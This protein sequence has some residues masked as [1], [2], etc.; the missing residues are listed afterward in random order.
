MPTSLDISEIEFIEPEHDLI[1]VPEELFFKD[2]EA[3]VLRPNVIPLPSGVAV[4]MRAVF[5]SEKVHCAR[6]KD[7]LYL[8]ADTTNFGYCLFKFVSSAEND[9]TFKVAFQG[10]NRIITK[11][12]SNIIM[13]GNLEAIAQQYGQRG[14]V[15][16]MNLGSS[17]SAPAMA[18]VGG[19][20]VSRSV[21]VRRL[22]SEIVTRGYVAGFVMGNA[23]ALTM[24]LSR[25]KSKDNTTTA[26]IIAK[27]SKPSRC[28]AVLLALPANC[29]QRNG[30]LATPDEIRSGGID[31]DTS[32]REMLYQY[33]PQNAAIGY[34][35]AIGGRLPEYA[36]FVSDAREQWSAED[37]LSGKPEVS[38]VYVHATENR[39]RNSSSKDQFRFSLKTTSGRR[40]LYTEKNHVCLRALEHTSVKCAT[41][42][43]AMRV[44]E[45]AFGAWKYR[46]KATEKET[47]LQKAMNECPSYIWSTK[48][49]IDGETKEGIGSCFFMVGTST[50]SDSGE[51]IAARPLTYVPWYQTG[52]QRAQMG[53]RVDRIVLRE[54][55]AASG[56][57]KENM[58]TKP[59]YFKDEPNNALFKPYQKFVEFITSTGFISRDKLFTLGTRASKARTKSLALTPEQKNSLQ[60]FLAREEID[61]EIQAVRDEAA[62]RAVLNST[63]R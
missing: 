27:E 48:Y 11:E 7:L 19:E 43:D 35:S 63:V 41:D 42:A 33:F 62:D 45:I 2:R 24:T 55:R 8:L 56:D 37:I 36:P 52:D 49:N 25:K 32:N 3:G 12:R 14:S 38:F 10:G 5:K 59:V 29:V 50:T 30:V 54:F 57:R 47:A 18:P 13:A 21:D 53:S 15:S 61:A 23:P 39:S 31:Y 16:A 26:N 40:S 9:T 4:W 6:T 58:V 34:I 1:T 60:Y 51:N 17:P 44:N 20:G 22:H 46:K 28:L